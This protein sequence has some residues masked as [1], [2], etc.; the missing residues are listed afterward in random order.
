M[1]GRRGGDE[2][3][4]I[5]KGV[6]HA[7]GPPYVV[8][9]GRRKFLGRGAEATSVAADFIERDEPGIAVEGRALE[10]LRDGWPAELPEADDIRVDVPGNLLC[11]V[12]IVIPH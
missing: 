1:C 11:V 9:D 10:S 5:A 12:P 3:I 7:A 6:T 4:Q 2:P 8:R